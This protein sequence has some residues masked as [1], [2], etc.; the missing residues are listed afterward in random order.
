[1]K[2]IVCPGCGASRIQTNNQTYCAQCAA[3]QAAANYASVW[4]RASVMWGRAKRRAGKKSTLFTITKTEIFDKL[5]ACDGFC[6]IT[7]EPFDFSLIGF[8][9]QN[10]RGPSVDQI[11]ASQGYTKENTQIVVWWYNAAKGNW[12]TEEEA[13]AKFGKPR[14]E[15][16]ENKINLYPERFG[17][18]KSKTG[19]LGVEKMDEGRYH[20]K[21]NDHKVGIFETAEVAARV[22]DF[23]TAKRLGSTQR[24][25]L[26]NF[27][28]EPL[29]DAPPPS[30]TRRVIH[31]KHVVIN[32]QGEIV[33]ISSLTRKEAYA[34]LE[35]IIT[36][37]PKGA[38][39]GRR[40]KNPL[41]GTKKEPSQFTGVFWSVCKGKW[42][43][44]I[45]IKKTK[46][47]LGYYDNEDDA[48]RDFMRAK[49][50]LRGKDVIVEENFSTAF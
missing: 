29:L 1:M 2:E 5:L 49:E 32:A 45:T 25:L 22:Y 41:I 26:L 15:G 7:G 35:G 10:A 20:V 3:N 23:Y 31:K 42:C 4:G 8:N 30:L 38:P 9:Q 17:S 13:R 39:K 44:R 46:I 50:R 33:K 27:P 6:P 43:S 12:F 48:H 16:A 19:Y 47:H 34:M 37:R 21:V 28:N 24:R 14:P 40:D 11:V 36:R 18:K